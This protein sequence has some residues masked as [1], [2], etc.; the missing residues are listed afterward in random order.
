MQITV[1]GIYDN[2]DEARA[3]EGELE[4]QGFSAR[5]IN[6]STEE[7]IGTERIEQEPE[8][9]RGFMKFF[10]DIFGIE[11]PSRHAGASTHGRY[12]LTLYAEQARAAVA[13]DVINRHHPIAQHVS[14]QRD[15]TP[16]TEPVQSSNVNTG[17]AIDQEM[18]GASS[19]SMGNEPLPRER[20]GAED[21]AIGSV[22][23][24][25]GAESLGRQPYEELP[26]EQLTQERTS[27]VYR[28]HFDENYAATGSRYD[29]YLPA[30]QFGARLA[31]DS[32][33]RGGQFDSFEGDVRREW[34]ASNPNSRWEQF[35]GA[36][37][38][39]WD[40]ATNKAV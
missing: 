36:I 4:S 27:D 10:R 5:D 37:R 6:I 40:R 17:V 20:L 15:V 11:E 39:A 30:Y 21:G 14:E 13:Q 22:S 29:E 3:T 38:H 9:E 28:A 25:F 1:I 16:V 8:H 19:E 18:A 32:R 2:I 12:V 34:E 24:S 33:Y 31:Q 23:Q 35:K 7:E 26:Q